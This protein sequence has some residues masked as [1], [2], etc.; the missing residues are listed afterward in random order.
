MTE[1]TLGVVETLEPTTK[2]I[3]MSIPKNTYAQETI[4]KDI[5]LKPQIESTTQHNLIQH[6]QMYQKQ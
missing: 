3:N 6:K 4:T 2:T 5:S 1:K